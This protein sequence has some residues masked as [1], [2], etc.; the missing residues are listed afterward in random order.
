[1]LGTYIENLNSR[2]YGKY[3]DR[4]YH[5]FFA[6][7]IAWFDPRTES[8]ESTQAL[9]SFFR[10]KT[11]IVYFRSSWDDNALYVGLKAGNGAVNH[12]HLDCGNFVFEAFGQRWVEDFGPDNYNLPGYFEYKP[13]GRRW[14]YFSISSLSHNVPT[15][16]SANQV[17]NANTKVVAYYSSPQKSSA[18]LDLSNA[19]KGQAKS[20]HRGLAMIESKQLLIQDEIVGLND[21]DQL[22]SAMLTSAEIKLYG[23]KAIL[24]KG[25][26]TLSAE[27]LQ[28]ESAAFNIAS[29]K[30]TY[31]PD[32]KPN[33]G[34]KLLTATLPLKA[35]ETTRVVI[36]L[37]PQKKDE[38]SIAVGSYKVIPLD[39]W[40]GYL[41]DQ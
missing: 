25:N 21:D 18:V 11:D 23:N 29:T 9:N 39:K 20:V 3:G 17:V 10:G 15:I 36:L 14:N 37:T 34:T 4:F 38:K 13:N 26:E 40:Q 30:P 35:G 5:R 41:I 16:N 8:K 24:K 2:N 31:H 28:P 1:M 7:E 12:S 22:R 19:Y 33:T 27:I 32:E 6:L